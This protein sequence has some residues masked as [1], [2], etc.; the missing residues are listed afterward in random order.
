MASNKTC[1]V[2]PL[3]SLNIEGG[4]TLSKFT[5][6]RVGGIA[7][8][9]AE[10]K[11]IKEIQF[12]LLWAKAKKIPCQIIGAGSNLLI[13][14]SE[15]KGLSICT[16]KMHK[17]TL[18]IKSGILEAESGAHL[19]T[20]ARQVAQ[21]G[22]GGLEWAVG[23]PGTVG[24]AVSMNAGAEGSCVAEWLQSIQVLPINGGK[25]FEIVKKDLDFSYRHSLLQ[26][27][28]LIVLSARFLLEPGHNPKEISEITNQ[29]LQKRTNSQPY[30]LPSCG[31]VFRNPEPLKAGRLIEELGLKGHRIGG[32]AISTR[33]ANF[34]VNTG[35]ATANDIY[36]LITFIQ[37]KVQDSH[38]VL[39]HPE[40]KQVGFDISD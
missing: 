4:K 37:K 28:K 24:G 9:F 12:L 13:S 27:E 1:S 6:L 22:L 3:A 34:I 23:I 31:S 32:A 14:D 40:V 26:K 10:P 29:N 20:L 8:W 7:Q 16:K 25:P 15:L 30:H 36:Q 33:H 5:T 2:T 11:N 19:P 18:N 35:Q 38:G 17:N 39:L 21:A